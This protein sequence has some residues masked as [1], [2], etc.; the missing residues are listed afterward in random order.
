[1]TTLTD[2]EIYLRFVAMAD[3]LEAM[4]REGA[5]FAGAAALQTACR[6]LR[7]MAKAIYEHSLSEDGPLQ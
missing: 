6:S 4:S 2:R 3:E 7:G 1:M 5:S